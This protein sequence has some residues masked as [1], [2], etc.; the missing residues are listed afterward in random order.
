MEL[1]EAIFTRR[2]IRKYKKGKVSPDVVKDLLRAA[3]AA[4]SAANRQPWHFVIIE[5]RS[6][7]DEIPK[8]HPHSEMLRD[9]ALAILVCGDLQKELRRG[10]F[11]LDCSAAV[12]NLLLAA[13]GKGLGAVWLGIYP[14]EDRIGEMRK[15]LKIPEGIVPF[16]LVSIGLPAEPGYAVDRYDETR[17]HRNHW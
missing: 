16:A 5:D 2:S 10:Y 6:I 1:F 12:Q 9:A 15:L 7:L 11:P 13:H 8:F 4:P 14:R 17:I 3:M